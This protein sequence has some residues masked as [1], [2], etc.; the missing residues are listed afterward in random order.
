M[1]V[2]LQSLLEGLSVQQTDYR[3]RQ[4]APIVQQLQIPLVGRDGS[5]VVGWNGMQ[6]ELSISL[7]FFL[8]NLDT[9]AVDNCLKL[10]RRN[11]R[12]L[13]LL[14]SKKVKIMLSFC[15]YL[16]QYLF[17]FEFNRI[18]LLLLLDQTFSKA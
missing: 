16:G 11:N 4:G 9:M 10:R 13:Q 7:T 14:S 17:T 3:S 5:P 1:Q 6:S 12:T 18:N 15:T 2:D 8:W